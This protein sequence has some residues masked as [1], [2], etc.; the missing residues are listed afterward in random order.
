MKQHATATAYSIYETAYGFGVVAASD[1]GL[2]AHHLPFGAP[3]IGDALELAA[4]VHP[5]AKGESLLTGEGAGLL[6]GYFAGEQV[7]FNLPLDLQGFTPF[8][9]SVYRTVAGIPYGTVLSYLEVAAACGSPR[10]AR[11]I[12][13]AMARNPLPILIPCHRVVGASGV[14]TGFTAPGGVASK[15]EILVMEGV[16]FDARGGVLRSGS[17]GV[18]HRISTGVVG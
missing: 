4:T 10:G 18:M 13:G 17:C 12:G 15:R 3:S 2:V 16:L 11:A 5:Q 14:M 1:N 7:V 6:K 8:Q 9:V